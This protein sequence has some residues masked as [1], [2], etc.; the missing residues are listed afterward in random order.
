MP[1]RPIAEMLYKIIEREKVETKVPERRKSNMIQAR[2]SL[3]CREQAAE[4]AFVA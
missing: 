4:E 1:G 3:T 2:A